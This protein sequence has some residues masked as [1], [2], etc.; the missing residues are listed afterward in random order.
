VTKRRGRTAAKTAVVVAVIASAA[1]AAVSA[2]GATGAAKK[3]TTINFPYLW[4]GPEAAALQKVVNQ[5]NKSQSAICVNGTSSP[6]FQKQL[7]QMSAGQGFDIS[8]N[9]G[10]TVASWA[11]KGILEPLDSYMKKDKYSQSDFVPAAINNQKYQGHTYALPIAV[12]TQLLMYNKKLFQGAGIAAPP[13]TL[14]Q[15]Q[16]DI[17]K[18]TKVDS[19]GNITQLGMEAPD[20]TIFGNAE[21][22]DWITNG[23]PTPDAAGNMQAL[24]FWWV[25]VVKKY[26]ASNLQKFTSGFGEYQSAQNPFYVGKVAMVIDGEWQPRFTKEYAPSLDW[27]VA[28]IPY[29]TGKPQLAGGTQLSSSMFFIPRNAPHKQQAWVFLKYLESPAAMRTFTFALGNLPARKSLITSPKYKSIPQFSAWL[30]SLNSKNVHIIANVP[31]GA[32]Y[33]Q[34]LQTYFGKI[35]SGEEAPAQAMKDAKNEALGYAG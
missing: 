31:W 5:F 11:T 26:G 25:N 13:K 32:Q 18:L 17:A 1:L 6:D 12:H 28:P 20:F 35:T 24:N 34:T 22:G 30:N 9:F 7:A 16:S 19:S 4:G 21:G 15:L 2:N 8:D 33:T 27:G 3:C 29:P 10:S 14:S 23:K